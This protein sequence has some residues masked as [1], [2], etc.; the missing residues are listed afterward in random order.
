ME[1]IRS[2]D[3]IDQKL[4][5]INVAA[6]ANSDAAV[7]QVFADFAMDFTE[8]YRDLPADPFS[9]EYYSYQ[10]GL[11]ETLAGK[12][13]EVKNEVS[14]FDGN[15]AI[16]RPFPYSSGNPTTAGMHLS[17]LGFV[18]SG[19]QLPFGS[20]IIEF[21]AG[22]G[23]TT[24]ALAMLGYDVTVVEIEERFCE[25]IRNRAKLHGVSVNVINGDFLSCEN[26]TEQYDGALFYECFHHCSDHM[27][28]LR[29]LHKIIKP[30][31]TLY[32]GAEPIKHDFPIPWG[33]RLDG[34][35]LWAIRQ[36]GWM[37]LGYRVDYFQEALKRTGWRGTVTVSQDAGWANLWRLKRVIDQEITISTSDPVISSAVPKKPDGSIDAVE[38]VNGY[39]MWGGY[40]GLASG[41]WNGRLHLKKGSKRGGRIVVDVCDDHGKNIIAQREVDL[42]LLGGDSDL[43]EIP[44]YLDS[45]SSNIEVRAV[46]GPDATISIAGVGVSPDRDRP[47][48]PVKHA[49]WAEPRQ[50]RLVRRAKR[51][52]KSVLT[53]LGRRA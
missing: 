36:N 33:L 14:I 12:S 32:L 18:I 30:G 19:I 16:T 43:I 47:A 39:L 13:Y 10:M 50:Q 9:N 8:F 45:V 51:A 11:Y 28:L 6:A 25:L 15:A 7:R 2:L 38:D 48:P 27:R 17:A 53:R 21:G 49:H 4:R 5:E 31:G 3:Q 52:V 35:S 34:E 41:G 22:W 1:I 40:L 44:F 42:G 23:N 24:L 46:M 20:R 29:G 37:E 26:M